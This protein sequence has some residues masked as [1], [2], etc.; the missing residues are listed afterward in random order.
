M[1]VHAPELSGLRTLEGAGKLER[2]CGM[3]EHLLQFVVSG[4]CT[5]AAGRGEWR[6][7]AGGLLWVR[8]WT[9]IA[10]RAEAHQQTVVHRLLLSGVPAADA[11]LGPAMYVERAWELRSTFEL[12]TAETQA[13]LPYRDERV[14]GLLLVLFT[15]L[16][17]RATSRPNSGLLSSSARYALEEYVDRNITARPQ[18]SDLARVAGLSPDYFTRVF[19]RTFGVPPREWVVRRRIQRAA[20]LLD[21]E[22]KPVAQVAAALGY[23]DSFLFSRQFKSVMGISPQSYRSR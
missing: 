13:T 3:P 2:P 20:V 21:Q 8:P 4:G 12:L 10:L 5:V 1:L 15:S 17:R 14:R 18:A 16:L 9:P 23:T 6:L 22:D 7:Q 19:R 11:C